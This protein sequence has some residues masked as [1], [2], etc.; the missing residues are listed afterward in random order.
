[1]RA[2]I[3]VPFFDTPENGR[4]GSTRR[5]FATLRGQVD[6]P[7]LIVAVDNGST[8]KRALHDVAELADVMVVLDQPHSIAYGVNVAWHLYEDELLRGES[9]AVKHDSDIIIADSSWLDRMPSDRRVQ[10]WSE[11]AI[12]GYEA[13]TQAFVERLKLEEDVG[14]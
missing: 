9:V 10:S 12:E 13:W 4:S 14:P 8:D 2:I 1:M 5:T 7:N 6:R 11:C 3:A